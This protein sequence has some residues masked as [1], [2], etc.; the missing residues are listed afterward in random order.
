M[1]PDRASSHPWPCLRPITQTTQ[2]L[3]RRLL[4]VLG[5]CLCLAG[6][7]NLDHMDLMLT[8]RNYHCCFIH[9]FRRLWGVL[10][11]PSLPAFLEEHFQN[12]WGKPHHV[13]AFL[14]CEG[15]PSDR[16][17]MAAAFQGQRAKCEVQF[18][19]S[20]LRCFR[21][22]F[23]S[24]PFGSHMFSATP[25]VTGAWLSTEYH[26]NTSWVSRLT[27]WQAWFCLLV[28]SK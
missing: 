24:S 23:G 2:I 18:L 7:R 14:G 13:L 19:L 22:T 15:W 28:D 17:G 8:S 12:K 27:G 5:W 25:S 21:F 11:D 26:Q 4:L 6:H 9:A 20:G 3:V 16:L 1:L 10:T